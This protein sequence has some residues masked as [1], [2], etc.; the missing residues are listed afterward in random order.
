MVGYAADTHRGNVRKLNEDCYEANPDLSLW[1]VADGVGGHACG[2]VASRLTRETITQHYRQSGDLIAAIEAAHKAVLDAIAQRQGGANMGSTVVAAT[3]NNRN[4]QIAWIGD[5]RAYAWNG[6][7]RLLSKDH[8]FVEALVSK[9]AITREEAFKHP[10]RNVI[11]QSI[12]V[13][14]D[15]DIEVDTISGVLTKGE[16]LLLCSDGLNDELRDSTIAE[17]LSQHIS[18][19]EQ[20]RQLMASALDAGG[21]DNITI[22]IID[23]DD[24]Q[25]RDNTTGATP[26]EHPESETIGENPD[27]DRHT[28]LAA[29]TSEP[30]PEKL[31][32]WKTIRK[33]FK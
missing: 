30:I 23:P 32:I 33:L 9:G 6:D 8:S 14:P 27:L 21:R 22:I 11:T 20:V 18:P 16:I 28:I 7:L 19:T 15:T 26:G 25:A 4:Y 2:D 10:K 29:S 1:L 3:L 12:G 31:S 17:V 24:Q 5:S 13:S